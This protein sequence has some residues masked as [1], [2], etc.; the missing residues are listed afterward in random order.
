MRGI[1]NKNPDQ[2]PI[3]NKETSIFIVRDDERGSEPAVRKQAENGTGGDT[4][5]GA[6]HAETK[7]RRNATD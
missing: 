2:V 3:I 1:H 5:S 7:G 6:T 4:A